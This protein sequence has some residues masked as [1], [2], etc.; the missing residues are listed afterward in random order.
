MQ[1]FVT[2]YQLVAKKKKKNKQSFSLNPSEILLTCVGSII[3]QHDFFSFSINDLI[4]LTT[5]FSLQGDLIVVH[6]QK[7]CHIC[8]KLYLTKQLKLVIQS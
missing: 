2:N 5:V 8:K 6:F 1:N 7:I 4:F 3:I